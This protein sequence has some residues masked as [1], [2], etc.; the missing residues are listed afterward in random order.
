MA[1]KAKPASTTTPRPNAAPA[2]PQGGGTSGAN[3]LAQYENALMG[4]VGRGTEGNPLGDFAQGANA[5]WNA[6][7]NLRDY[8]DRLRSDARAHERGMQGDQLRSQEA[9]TGMQTAAQTRTA[10]IQ[11]EAQQAVAGTQASSD[12]FQALKNLEG[13]K[14]QTEGRVQEARIGAK[15][16]VDV[17]G[18]QTAAQRYGFEID[19][20]IAG[21]QSRTQRYQTD[22]EAGTQRYATDAQRYLGELDSGTKRYLGELEAG[23]QKYRTNAELMG[24]LAGLASSERIAQGQQTGESER[25]RMQLAGSILMNKEDNYTA[26]SSK[27][28]DYMGNVAQSQW[29]APDANNIRYWG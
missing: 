23:T 21:I 22:V 8:G 5:F 27:F 1:T 10:S 7:S 9:Q 2:K 28:F 24:N 26:R 3:F 20:K 18:L 6:S 11:A 12:R 16:Q 15:A 25:T 4:G 13:I 19:E 17:A 29:R 14:A